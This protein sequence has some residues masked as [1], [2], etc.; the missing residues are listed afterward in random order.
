MSRIK[1]H[2]NRAK[3]RQAREGWVAQYVEDGIPTM[4]IFWTHGRYRSRGARLRWLR[5]KRGRS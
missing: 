4:E 1:T 3:R 2:N 5:Q